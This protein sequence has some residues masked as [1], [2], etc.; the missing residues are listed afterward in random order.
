[1]LAKGRGGGVV[2]GPV[3]DTEGRARRQASWADGVRGAVA[4]TQLTS[5]P[6][7]LY[8]Y[9]M[10]TNSSTVLAVFD[11]L[12]LLLCR[13][14]V[15]PRYPFR[16]VTLRPVQLARA[17]GYWVLFMTL[18][19]ALPVWAVWGTARSQH[20]L[21]AE[22]VAIAGVYMAVT[23]SL[24]GLFTQAQHW[25]DEAIEG[26]SAEVSWAERTVRISSDYAVGSRF[27]NFASGGANTHV[28]HHLFPTVASDKLRLLAPVVRAVSKE[29]GVVSAPPERAPQT[30][31]RSRSWV[32]EPT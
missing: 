21:V 12:Y 24:L 29:F 15:L 20:I 23:G 6:V 2:I 5:A 18:L 31:K 10:W 1:V 30:L 4:L 13:S 28:A 22:R 16:H 19:L 11:P 8:L 25:S 26:G 17:M 32:L 3:R 7:R 14:A 9:W 27:W